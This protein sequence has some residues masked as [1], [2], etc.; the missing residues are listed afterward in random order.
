METP[1]EKNI[2][3]TK[4]LKKGLLGNLLVFVGFG[5]LGPLMLAIEISRAPEE[6]G[7]PSVGSVVSPALQAFAIGLLASGIIGKWATNREVVHF[8]ITNE[9]NNPM[10]KA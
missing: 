10:A 4:G 1:S 3:S 6:L 5:F 7:F 8:P 9:V 2:I